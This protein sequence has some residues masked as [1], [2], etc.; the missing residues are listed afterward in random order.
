MEHNLN[1]PKPVFLTSKTVLHQENQRLQLN[2]EKLIGESSAS[3]QALNEKIQV[4]QATVQATVDPLTN[5]SSTSN[6]HY[7]G[8]PYKTYSSKIKALTEKYNGESDWGCMTVRN[9]ID[10]R[11]AFIIGNGAKAI[12][13]DG[14]EGTAERELDFIRE[15]IRFNDLDKESPNDWAVGAELEG[16]ALIKLVV[17]KKERNIRTVYVPWSKYPYTVSAN[18]PDLYKYTKAFYQGTDTIDASS[19][20]PVADLNRDVD[21]NLKENE[22]IYMRFG[23]S[24]EK[25]NEPIP[26]TALVLR[27]VEDLDKELWDWRKINHLFA[28]PTPIF[29]VETIE[30]CERLQAWIKNEN[31]RIGKSIVIANGKF[32]LVCYSGEGFTTIKNALEADVTTISGSTGVPVHFL[33]HPELLSNRATATSLLELTE[34]ATNRERSVWEGGYE[35]IYQKAMVLANDNF[36]TGYKP[37]AVTAKIPFISSTKLEFISNVYLPMYEANTISL[38]TFLSYLADIDVDEEIKRIE[39]DKKKEEVSNAANN[40]GTDAGTL[41]GRPGGNSQPRSTRGNKAVRPNA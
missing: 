39:E 5:T 35:E 24:S 15:F 26:K 33:G 28:A 22:F 27:Q 11:A 37:D 30:E 6:E 12:K 34:L 19:A 16:K 10:V 21:F 25:I 31:W 23:G 36:N 32:D 2:Q 20:A 14:Y 4:L 7:T 40:P 41:A 29:T 3:I 18:N 8:N 9:I 1:F 38:E 13:Q 17:D